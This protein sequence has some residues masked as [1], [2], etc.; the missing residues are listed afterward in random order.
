MTQFVI[1]RREMEMQ[2]PNTGIKRGG[3]DRGVVVA[4]NLGLNECIS[5]VMV[6]ARR[7]IRVFMRF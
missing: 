5:V 7:V 4:M 3:K 1:R 6:M 2:F